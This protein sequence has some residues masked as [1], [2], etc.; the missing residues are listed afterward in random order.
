MIELYIEKGNLESNRPWNIEEN[1]T[2]TAQQH[3][4]TPV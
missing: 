3:L 4:A 2:Y 1:N